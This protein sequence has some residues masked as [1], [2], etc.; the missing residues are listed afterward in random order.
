MIYHS[1]EGPG[2]FEIGIWWDG[3]DGADRYELQQKDANDN[4]IDLPGGGSTLR[5]GDGPYARV[6]NLPYG[7]SYTHRVRALNDQA[8]SEWSDP[9]RTDIR[10]AI[11]AGHQ[12]DHVAKYQLASTP[13][14]WTHQPPGVSMTP[15]DM[16]ES[17]L[18]SGQVAWTLVITGHPGLN[19]SGLRLCNAC[20]G[21]SNHDG[22]TITVR[23][24]ALNTR[25]EADPDRNPNHGCGFASACVK[26]QRQDR[27]EKHIGSST[28]IFEEPGFVYEDGKD[29]A[30][31]WTLD[32][33]MQNQIV[34]DHNNNEIGVYR[35][36]IATATH[37]MGHILGLPDFGAPW[38]ELVNLDG[39]MKDSLGHSFPQPVDVSHLW[40]IYRG[41]SKA[42]H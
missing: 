12:E 15:G 36:M 26:G 39:L 3:I 41:H 13:P 14:T 35:Y 19:A 9:Y 2:D 1:E 17:A 32:R 20:P 37:E 10:R 5:L 30:V 6:G 23:F 22:H 25:G 34:R 18:G 11:N 28:M 31:Y 29:N 16:L 24:V 42:P 4:W 38:N 27:F 40:K 7:R 33:N 21:G 8:Q